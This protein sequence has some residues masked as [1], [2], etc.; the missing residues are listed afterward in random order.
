MLEEVVHLRASPGVAWA[1]LSDLRRVASCVPGAQIDSVDGDRVTGRVTLALGPIRASFAGTGQVS[2]H[3][4]SQMGRLRGGGRDG[5]SRA[6]GEVVWTV[7][8]GPRGGSDVTVRLCW[9]LTGPLAQFGRAALVR[10]VVRRVA[11]DFARNLDPIVAG[12]A[13]LPARP[14]GLF[15]MLW[16]LL[17]ARLFG[18]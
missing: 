5:A 7:A 17:K 13:L 4:A 8:P 9:R 12:E 11:R 2:L 6:E 1:A 3:E 14:V 16:A 10:D 18:H 15:A